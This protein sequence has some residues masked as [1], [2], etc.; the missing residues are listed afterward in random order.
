MALLLR[1]E[2]LAP[3]R[4]DQL[5][6]ENFPV[7]L[8]ILP[9]SLRRDLLAVYAF[10]RHVDELGEDRAYGERRLTDIADDLGRLAV[11]EPPVQPVVAAVMPTVVA[12]HVPVEPLLAL[13]EANR[14]DLRVAR[15]E[16][17]D[18]LREYCRLSADPVGEIVLHVF[19][20][21]TPARLELSGRICTGL[22]LVEHWQDVAEDH[23]AGRVYLPQDDM[24]RFGVPESDL[25]APTA[26][27]RLR[28]LLAFENDRA[29][30]W[31]DAGAP[32]VSGLH[33]WARLAVSAYLAGGRAATQALRASGHDPLA[34]PVKPTRAQVGAM[35]LRATVRWPG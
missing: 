21:V 28:A 19:G 34:G 11:G 27:D 2:R 33:G 26:S 17:F 5:R 3:G 18:D 12:R 16:T 31:L 6:G 10:A 24:R 22:Q 8:G 15:Y 1:G 30:A 7:A 13:V 32:L 14:R 23:R 35:W 29:R 25:A 9:T 20:A 4:R